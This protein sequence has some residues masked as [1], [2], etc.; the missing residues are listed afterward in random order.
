MVTFNLPPH[1]GARWERVLDTAES[2]WRRLF[3][4]RGGRYRARGRSVVLFRSRRIAPAEASA[5]PSAPSGAPA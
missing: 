4:P 5:Q 3:V 1:P 2:D